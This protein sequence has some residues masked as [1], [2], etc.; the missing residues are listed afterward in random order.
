MENSRPT[1]ITD[2]RT[3]SCRLWRRLF[4]C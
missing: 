1:N 4:R 3:L 2:N